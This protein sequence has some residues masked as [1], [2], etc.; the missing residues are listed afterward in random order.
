MNQVY[1]ALVG[2]SLLTLVACDVPCDE[3]LKKAQSCFKK[4]GKVEKPEEVGQFMQVCKLNSSKFEKC[5]KIKDCKAYSDCLS[6]AG[7][8]PK[9][10]ESLAILKK[11]EE[12]EKAKNE[13]E[14]PDAMAA[15]PDAM[16]AAPDAMAVAPDA[17]AVAPDAMAV[18]PDA[19]AAAPAMK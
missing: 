16:D 4:K 2:V 19:M 14:N 5:L 11:T 12:A 6:K 17:M 15:A 13:A 1:L 10:V 7:T 18:A 9:A 3:N 8:D